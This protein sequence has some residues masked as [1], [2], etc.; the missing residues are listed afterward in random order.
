MG[1]DKKVEGGRIRFVLLKRIGEAYVSGEV[2]RAALADVLDAG[3]AHAGLELAPYAARP[4]RSR[5]RRHREPPPRGRSEYQRD[6]DRIVHST[7]FRRLEYKT[8][9]F[10]NHEGDLFRTRLTHSLE[11]AQIARSV[12]RSLRLDED[13]T[14]AIALAHDLGHTPVRPHRAGLAQR[15]HEALRGLRA[16]PSEPARGG[17]PRAALR[18]VRRPQSDLRD[19]RGNI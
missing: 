2:P 13:L 9:V 5:G 1:H 3:A 8:Q 17:R 12:A 18:R 10:V 16:Q 14:E 15:L 7:A 6:R 4:E 19:A 11:V